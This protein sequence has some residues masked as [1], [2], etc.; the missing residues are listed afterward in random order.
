[1]SEVSKLLQH[2]LFSRKEK[3]I[4]VEQLNISLNRAVQMGDPYFGVAIH[5][6]G[7]TEP[8]MIVFP[9]S[10]Y[11]NKRLYYC[12]AYTTEGFLASSLNGPITHYSSCIWLEAAEGGTSA[13]E[14]CDKLLL[15]TRRDTNA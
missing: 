15:Q 14:V 13:A 10:S 9:R 3:L 8:E 7:A 6:P 1:M 5:T 4:S 2:E 11:N 12:M